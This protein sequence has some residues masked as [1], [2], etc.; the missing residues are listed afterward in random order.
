MADK[1]A[2]DKEPSREELTEEADAL[3]QQGVP[4]VL[5]DTDEAVKLLGKV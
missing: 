4:L 1:K 2:D 3:F 5:K